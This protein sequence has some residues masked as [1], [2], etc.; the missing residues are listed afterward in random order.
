MAG[1][2]SRCRLHLLFRCRRCCVP[3]PSVVRCPL[4]SSAMQG[5]PWA[6]PQ[7]ASD[8]SLWNPR[9]VD[10]FQIFSIDCSLL[11]SIFGPHLRWAS[12]RSDQ[13]RLRRLSGMAARGT[14]SISHAFRQ[15]PPFHW[16]PFNATK[17]GRSSYN[18]GKERT[19]DHGFIKRHQ[20]P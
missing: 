13:K 5:G 1:H 2:V 20:R 10:V 11:Q 14:Y 16:G 6:H 18:Q 9:L 15:P 12:V 17:G 4:P 19:G 3:L 7:P 8:P